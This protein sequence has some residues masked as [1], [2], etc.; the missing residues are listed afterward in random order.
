MVE[1]AGALADFLDLIDAED[2][3]H[4]SVRHGWDIGA[5]VADSVVIQAA[6]LNALDRPTAARPVALSDY[7]TGL[8]PWLHRQQ[9]LAIELARH[10][11]IESLALRY[12][13]DTTELATRLADPMAPDAVQTEEHPLRTLD[14]IR[15]LCLQLVV[16]CDDLAESLPD[17][18]PLQWSRG[19]RAEAVRTLAD[20]IAARHPGGSVELRIPPFAAVQCG[21]GEDDP[22][23]TRGT[24]PNV[25]ECDPLILVRLCIGRLKF[26]DA[27]RTGAV[28]ASGSRSDLS[29]WL[30]LL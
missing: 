8:R 23:H 25:V 24:P 2:L 11:S 29:A 16:H 12:R 27:V 19:C 1:Q 5:L 10:G 7:F 17:R 3:G 4:P 6:A 9:E 18:G 21:T 28:R 13:Q 14:L 30:P 22:R 20:L 15:M 26:A